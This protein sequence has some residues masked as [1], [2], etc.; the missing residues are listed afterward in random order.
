[1]RLSRYAAGP[2][3][4]T[5]V[6]QGGINTSGV[7]SQFYNQVTVRTAVTPDLVFP[8]TANGPP[9]SAASQQLLDQLQPTI[10]LSGPA[11][12]YTLAPYGQAT[13]QRSWLPIA[14]VGVGAVLF[15]GWAVFGR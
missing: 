4:N 13:G 15:I 12:E 14:L 7:I 2:D 6:N 8:I 5:F 9:P 10:I 3:L 11:G 1:M